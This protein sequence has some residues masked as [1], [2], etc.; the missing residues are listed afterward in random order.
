MMPT[1]YFFWMGEGWCPHCG[2]AAVAEHMSWEAEHPS[3]EAAIP[4]VHPVAASAA[5]M[6][7]VTAP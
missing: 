7:Q 1:Y 6:Y 3:A 2:A 5:Y 4:K